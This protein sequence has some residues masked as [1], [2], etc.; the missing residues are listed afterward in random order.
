M[1]IIGKTD[2]GKSRAENQDNFR[3]GYLPLEGAWG[4]VCD[5]MGGAQNGRLAS[6][7][8]SESIEEQFLQGLLADIEPD[9]V[10]ELMERA[11]QL[12]NA[13]VFARS[14]NGEQVMGTTVVCAIIKDGSLHLCHVGDSRAYL[15]E[16]NRLTQLTRDHS[17]VQELVDSGALT[18][19]E[20][21]HHP[22]K[23][24]IT[25]A[26]GV[27]EK[28]ETTY[29]RRPFLPGSLLLLCSD[30]LTNMVPE[31][32]IAEILGTVDFF[33]MPNELVSDA[34]LAGGSDNITVL[35]LEKREGEGNG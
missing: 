14:G 26:L 22:E 35:I 9:A 27:E 33:D 30:G 32:R 20:A 15:F 29:S 6:Q 5:G 10:Q 31:E 19:D 11:V 13:E 2:I 12:A 25:R 4:I 23:N 21:S 24:V 1:R 3:S 34:L 28:V 18:E 8:A 7:L 16:Q 17:M